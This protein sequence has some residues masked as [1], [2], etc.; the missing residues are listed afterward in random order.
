[1]IP[2]EYSGSGGGSDFLVAFLRSRTALTPAR[3]GGYRFFLFVGI[4]A[5]GGRQSLDGDPLVLG[6]SLGALT[7]RTVALETV[8]LAISAVPATTALVVFGALIVGAGLDHFFFILILVRGVVTALAALL[9]EPG[10]VLSQ[11]T[12]IM[13]RELEVIFAL[14]A[15][16]S[17]L[18]VARH[19][20]VFLEQLRRVSTL[21]VVLP[22]APEIRASLAPT[23]A[24]AAALS[25]VDQ[26]PT[27]LISRSVPPL[28]LRAAGTR[29][30]RFRFIVPICA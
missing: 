27:S 20:L 3:L 15:I 29:R 25:I 21:A 6:F 16:A 23:A 7:R 22:V 26:M 8:A 18:G 13:V 17:E 9:F 5:D 28:F 1:L 30:M 2:A 14:H 11:D 12:E 10:A 4:A 19:V 24:T